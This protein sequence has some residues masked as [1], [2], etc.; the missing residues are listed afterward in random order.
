MVYAGAR[1]ETA[2]QMREALRFPSS[3]DQPHID[4]AGIVQRLDQAGGGE[5]EMAVAN[6]LWAQ[7]GAALRA[8]FLDLIARQYGGA[9]NL[10]DFHHGA[11][12]ARGTINQWVADKTRRKIQAL[13]PPGRVDADTRLILVNA[14]YFK[15]RWVLPFRKANTREAPFYLGGGGTVHTRLMYQWDSFRHVRAKGYQAI[16]LDYRGD[17]LSM[18][19]LLPDRKNGLPAL[20]KALSTSMADPTRGR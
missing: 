16:D 9:T 15:G 2:A 4:F 17:D 13:I 10:V 8:E 18:L 11:E 12:S 3:D 5:Y 19:V 14:L 7:D 20:E 1:G 6:A